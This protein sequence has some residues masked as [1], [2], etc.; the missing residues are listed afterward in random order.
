MV[1]RRAGIV[2]AALLGAAA[3][4]VS[5]AARTPTRQSATPT[6]SRA[7]PSA[8]PRSAPEQ[9]AVAET[10]LSARAV[11]PE[12]LAL[13]EMRAL[14][15]QNRISEARARARSFFAEHPASPLG[16]SVERLTGVHPRPGLPE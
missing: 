13:D 10:A 12:A 2:L 11:D 4:G 14:V 15:R 8:V 16:P 9:P 3:V 1:A 5:V 6:A 7:D